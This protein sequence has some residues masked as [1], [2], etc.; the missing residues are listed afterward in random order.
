MATWSPSLRSAAVRRA[1]GS[2]RSGSFSSGFKNSLGAAVVILA[3]AISLGIAITQIGTTTSMWLV[4]LWASWVISVVW[5]F[6]RQTFSVAFAVILAEMLFF[7][8]IPATVH[9]VSGSTLIG[10]DN[11]GAGTTR[12]VKIC[13]LAQCATFVGALFARTFRPAPSFVRIHEQ[14]SLTRLDRVAYAALVAGFFG[15]FLDVATGAGDLSNFFSFATQSGYD[16]FYNPTGTSN[17]IDLAFQLVGGLAVIAAI[18]RL[19]C[20]PPKYSRLV[21]ILVLVASAILLLGIGQR[22]RFFVPLLA[23][24]LVWFKTSRRRPSPRLLTVIAIVVAFA[25]STLIGVLRQPAGFRQL[26]VQNITFA[27]VGGGNELF[28][29]LAGLVQT[30]PSQVRYLHGASY[31]ETFEIPIPRVIW[32]SKP[33]GDIKLV[34]EDFDPRNNGLAFPEFGEMYANFGTI[35]VVIGSVL[36][37]FLVEGLW[38][39]IASTQSIREVVVLSVIFAIVAQI[40]VRGAIAGMFVIFVGLLAATLYV[41]RRNSPTFAPDVAAQPP[42]NRRPPPPVA[43]SG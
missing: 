14:L 24:G 30:V 12:A 16:S 43:L 4:I 9:I 5:T 36:V 27:S 1:P 15:L 7:V 3:L 33:T 38:I 42:R 40:F 2:N 35:G 32:P 17:G 28:A 22:G 34:T 37:A 13:A 10:G 41:C 6:T 20:T 23:A 26:S 8:I 19:T 21:P 25:A 11:F 18:L 31:L 39:R 29:P